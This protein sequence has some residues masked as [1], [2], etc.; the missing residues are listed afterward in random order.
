MKRKG[1]KK[2][3]GKKGKLFWDEGA[4][5]KLIKPTQAIGFKVEALPPE[6]KG[7][8]LK[9]PTVLSRFIKTRMPVVTDDSTQW[10]EATKESNATAFIEPDRVSTEDF[11]EYTLKWQEFLKKH[12]ST[13]L[14]GYCWKVPFKGK[15][16]KRSFR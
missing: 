3:I 4:N 7:T 11:N 16:T 8:S 15:V 5:Q 14:E 10:K 6:Y 13:T 9:D 1:K 12:T 2:P